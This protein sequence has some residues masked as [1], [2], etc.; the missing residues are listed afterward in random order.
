MV[1]VSV[2]LSA[3]IIISSLVWGTCSLP[4]KSDSLKVDKK[5]NFK[6]FNYEK[7]KIHRDPD[8]GYSQAV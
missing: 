5:S 1:M 4:Y 6:L 2:V 8:S 7:I 3:I